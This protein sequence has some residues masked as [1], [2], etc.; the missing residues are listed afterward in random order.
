LA[1]WLY[2]D[3][4]PLPVLVC[5]AA[6]SPWQGSYAIT[7]GQLFIRAGVPRS[8]IW[9]AERSHT[10]HENAFYGAEVLR[11][12]GVSTI[13]LV[14]ESQS[15]PRPAAL[16]SQGRSDCGAGTKLL[17]RIPGLFF[18]NSCLAGTPSTAMK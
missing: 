5:G 12:H 1:A 9:L 4:K 7:K 11:Q 14:V 3:W 15:M 18:R 17:S 16:F 2:S 10:T 13:A 8:M 6:P